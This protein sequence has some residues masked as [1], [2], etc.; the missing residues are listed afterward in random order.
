MEVEED[1]DLEFEALLKECTTDISAAEYANF[2]DSGSE[3]TPLMR[4]RIEKLQVIRSK[5]FP[6]I[7]GAM[8]KMTSWNKKA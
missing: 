5:R 8:M 2:D 1:D 3:N 7:T 4:F 6:M